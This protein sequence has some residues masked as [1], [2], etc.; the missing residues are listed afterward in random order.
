MREPTALKK[1]DVEWSNWAGDEHCR[2]AAIV[3]PRSL[4]EIAAALE[5]AAREGLQVR[6]AGAGHS[7]TDIACTDGLLI[8]LDR[9]RGVLDVDRE[10]GL[11]RVQAGITIGQL[12]ARLAEHH[13]ALENLGDLHG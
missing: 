12:N 1:N 10:S 9:M 5:R 3:H 4:A 7:F 8:V 11:V 13:P 6:V 2:P